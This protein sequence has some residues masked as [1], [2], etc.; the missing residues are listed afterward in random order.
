MLFAGAG[1]ESDGDRLPA[2]HAALRP[3]SRQVRRSA[4]ATN[5]LAPYLPPF[6]HFVI[7]YPDAPTDRFLKG[8]Y[9]GE[10]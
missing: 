5:P 8:A 2:H 9:G 10:R 6:T 4:A 3:A 1:R 7:L